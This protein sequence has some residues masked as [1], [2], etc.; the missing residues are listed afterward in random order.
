MLQSTTNADCPF[1]VSE[2]IL[3]LGS[4]K[5]RAALC[6]IIK[7]IKELISNHG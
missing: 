7:A 2:N 4:H 1:F 3:F 5:I 6:K